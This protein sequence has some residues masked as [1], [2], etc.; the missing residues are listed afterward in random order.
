MVSAVVPP[1]LFRSNSHVQAGPCTSYFWGALL[2]LQFSKI[3][4]NLQISSWISNFSIFKSPTARHE[5]SQLYPLGASN[6]T[7]W[8]FLL[9]PSYYPIDPPEAFNWTSLEHP[10]EPPEAFY[11]TPWSIQLNPLD[12]FNCTWMDLEHPIEPPRG[13]Q[14]YLDG[15]GASN[16]TPLRPSTVPRCDL[17]LHPTVTSSFTHLKISLPWEH[18]LQSST[19]FKVQAKHPTPHHLS[20]PLPAY[21]LG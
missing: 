16:W 9:Y 3:H 18:Q 20:P 6:W 7:P 13:L 14:L 12:A 4:K 21:D 8:G 10:I 15:L 17:Q 2:D 5:I 11:C 1:I 19:P